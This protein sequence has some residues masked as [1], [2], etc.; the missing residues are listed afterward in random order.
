MADYVYAL[1]APY[2]QHH[3]QHQQPHQQGPG[4][5]IVL[6]G[7]SLA[8]TIYLPAQ[9]TSSTALLFL[10]VIPSTP[11]PSV[12]LVAPPYP[13]DEGLLRGYG[14]DA[15]S[16]TSTRSTFFHG[17]RDQPR[18]RHRRYSRPTVTTHAEVPSIVKVL[19]EEL[20]TT[21]RKPRHCR[22][23]P[24][25]RGDHRR[26]RRRQGLLV[27]D[28]ISGVYRAPTCLSDEDA[29]TLRWTKPLAPPP[30]AMDLLFIL[31]DVL[32]F[33]P[34]HPGKGPSACGY[35]VA[36]CRLLLLDGFRGTT[37]FDE[38]HVYELAAAVYLPLAGLP[39]AGSLY[40]TA[41]YEYMP[42]LKK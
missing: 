2:Q 5:P 32:P 12:A 25:E 6:E 11:L 22:Y 1:N 10:L 24:P 31:C 37:P 42:V 13:N 39:Q 4:P 18:D 41:R 20:Q 8:T 27:L 19:W 33:E 16:S 28:I 38:V 14:L 35:R 23:H 36:P 7:A 15:N 30:L 29:D 3:Q 34:R 17:K 40:D 26:R 9:S 21:G